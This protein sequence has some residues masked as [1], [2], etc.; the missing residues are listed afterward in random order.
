MYGHEKE[1]IMPYGVRKKGEQYCVYNKDTGEEKACH[2]T[3]EDAERQRRLLEAI[4]HD[5]GFKPRDG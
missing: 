4:E 1:V 2:A 3:E 5:E